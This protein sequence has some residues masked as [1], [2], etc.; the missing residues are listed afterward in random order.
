VN[1]VLNLVQAA[2]AAG[3]RLEARLWCDQL[4]QLTPEMRGALGANRSAVLRLLLEGQINESEAAAR[5]AGTDGGAAPA[6]ASSPALDDGAQHR[7]MLDGHHRM[8]LRLPPSW[9]PATALPSSGAYCSRCAGHRWWCERVGTQGWRCAT[10]YP[11]VH[12]A[13]EAVRWVET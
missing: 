3:V 10:C 4:D 9:G 13:Q 7:V 11:P 8:A 1:V 12:L 2:V 6:P 5:V